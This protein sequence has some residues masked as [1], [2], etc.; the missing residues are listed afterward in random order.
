MLKKLKIKQRHITAPTL[1]LLTNLECLR[2]GEGTRSDL[3]IAVPELTGL[4]EL[5]CNRPLDFP[6]L[7][8]LTNLTALRLAR[9]FYRQDPCAL[10]PHLRTLSL[11]NLPGTDIS[12]LWTSLT[13]LS[14]SYFNPPSRARSKEA[15]RVLGT[16]TNLTKLRCMLGSNRK[17]CP[18]MLQ[19]LTNLR[20][21]TL[22]PCL[23]VGCFTHLVNLKSTTAFTIRPPCCNLT[24]LTFLE[25]FNCE[26]SG[27]ASKYVSHLTNL[28]VLKAVDRCPSSCL[29]VSLEKLFG[30]DC[31]RV[32]RVS[33]LTNL[34][35]LAAS[36]VSPE[37]LSTLTNLRSLTV[38]DR[39]KAGPKASDVETLTNLTKLCCPAMVIPDEVV[40]GL[41]HLLKVRRRRGDGTT[42]GRFDLVESLESNTTFSSDSFSDH[43]SDG[44]SFVS[45]ESEYESVQSDS[46]EISDDTADGF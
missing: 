30:A 5:S 9:G 18:D 35:Y 10:L 43:S 26:G 6:N 21:L 4:L 15:S 3:Q 44:E 24:Q 36:Y 13:S 28:R 25:K 1:S 23:P 19:N 37:G 45:V 34:T 16:F 42:Q 20:S 31:H 17:F 22:S 27:S 38:W 33:H 29:P 8:T 14:V 2:L 12:P 7:F 41:P 46:D 11:D 40:E 32:G 39:Y